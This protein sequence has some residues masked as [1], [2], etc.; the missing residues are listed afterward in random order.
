MQNREFILARATAKA[1]D[2]IVAFALLKAF[3]EVGFVGGLL[4]LTT[5]DGFFDGRSPG[6]YLL[7]LKVE[8]NSQEFGHLLSSILRNLNIALAFVITFVPYAGW[9]LFAGILIVDLI[10]MIGN[11]GRRIGDIVANTT[12]IRE[13]RNVS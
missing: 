13:E 10:V 1:I 12:V 6:K 9:F 3:Q 4:Y 8:C 11:N 7:R 5:C 2:L